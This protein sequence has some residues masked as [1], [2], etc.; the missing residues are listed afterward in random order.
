MQPPASDA[1]SDA[2][3][4]F[5]VIHVR[6]ERGRQILSCIAQV[7]ALI[8]TAVVLATG[9]TGT[10]DGPLREWLVVNVA[11]ILAHGTLQALDA[12]QRRH[13]TDHD[14]VTSSPR[15]SQLVGS[16]TSL[17]VHLHRT[18]SREQT[19]EHDHDHDRIH[20]NHRDSENEHHYQHEP[21]QTNL[22]C[23]AGHDLSNSPTVSRATVTESNN[24][25]ALNGQS[26]PPEQSHHARLSNH[27][28]DVVHR[29][30][31]SA[32]SRQRAFCG[33]YS[34]AALLLKL[35]QGFW[36]VWIVSGFVM[37]IVFRKCH[38]SAPDVHSLTVALSVMFMIGSQ[39]RYVSV[40]ILMITPAARRVRRLSEAALAASQRRPASAEEISNLGIVPF[41]PNLFPDPADKVCAI[42]LEQYEINDELRMLPCRDTNLAIS[43]LE[44]THEKVAENFSSN[45]GV[46][47][48]SRAGHYF[49]AR[50]IDAWLVRHAACPVC[51]QDI[52]AQ[53]RVSAN[54]FP[55]LMR[56]AVVGTWDG[57]VGSLSGNS[58]HSDSHGS[59]T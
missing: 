48:C 23:D 47:D 57:L 3:Q 49:H 44:H 33:I 27:S 53:K 51:K 41:Y 56:D 43:S 17:A 9:W 45:E 55:N 59:D 6:V 30:A 35:V 42:C 28:S 31:L 8:S 54:S 52:D 5:A 12:S 4:R 10:C 50:C 16:D 34:T 11:C 19:P 58:E 40:T 38:V 20:D 13:A 21:S 26:E 14:A 37:A 22:R 18:N 25:V 36:A 29:T 2:L 7:A 32:D 15:T 1:L 46:K 24:A 39:L